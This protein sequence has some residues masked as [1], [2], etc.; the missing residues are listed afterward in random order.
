M[1]KV[2]KLRQVTSSRDPLDINKRLYQ[3]T[4]V[5]LMELERPDVAEH[6][7]IRERI[8]LFIAIGRMQMMFVGLRKEK[9]GDEHSGSAVRKY[10]AN[11]KNDTSQRKKIAR[12]AKQ[13]DDWFEQ[14]EL[15]ALNNDDDDDTD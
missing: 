7:T 9:G 14:P 2:V 15:A 13:P 8:A 11:F 5:M 3:Q 10:E 6:I 12:S 1:G 4:H